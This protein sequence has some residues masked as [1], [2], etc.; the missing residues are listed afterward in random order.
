[1]KLST[2]LKV[3]VA[4]DLLHDGLHLGRGRL[5][6]LAV[7]LHVPVGHLLHD[8]VVRVGQALA[9]GA[10]R[11]VLGLGVADAL[12][13]REELVVDL[14]LVGDGE[15]LLLL[16]VAVAKVVAV[17]RLDKVPAV[18]LV[19]RRGTAVRGP[20]EVGG[21]L[22]LAVGDEGVEAVGPHAGVGRRLL[23]GE[24]G[25]LLDGGHGLGD[26]DAGL[27]GGQSKDARRG[28]GQDGGE[29]GGELHFER[30]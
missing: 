23:L 24:S 16:V 15:A 13:V 29:E 8:G 7:A 22:L 20:L 21:V 6:L 26:G 28:N 9:L 4:A 27:G 1:V 30:V 25:A 11:R 12:E 17:A 14:P 3:E 10:L 5:Q 19:G 18:R 2:S